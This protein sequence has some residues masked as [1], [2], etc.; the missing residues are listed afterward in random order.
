MAARL[1][2]TVTNGFNILFQFF[3]LRHTDH[4]SK[5][6]GF[7]I[8]RLDSARCGNKVSRM[9]FFPP[10]WQRRKQ[11]RTPSTCTRKVNIAK[12]FSRCASWF[13]WRRV[14]SCVLREKSKNDTFNHSSGRVF[15]FK[16][17]LNVEASPHSPDL[18]PCDC[19]LL[20]RV[21]GV[22]KET[23]FQSVSEIQSNVT[24]ILKQIPDMLRSMEPTLECV[25]VY[26]FKGAILKAMASHL[27]NFQNK[28][29]KW[30]IPERRMVE[31][32]RF[33]TWLATKVFYKIC[34]YRS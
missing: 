3:V 19:F 28:I 21:K 23:H 22:T 5:Q 4:I 11:L 27:F 13:A 15:N 31:I 8:L 10:K 1:R 29:F 6:V 2:I 20:P 9:I 17:D 32:D 24:Q 16:I 34:F 25:Y 14:W 18:S 30:I 12:R 26:S 7:T 33:W